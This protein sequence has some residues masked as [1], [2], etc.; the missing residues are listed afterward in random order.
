MVMDWLEEL[1]LS[2]SSLR[3]GVEQIRKALPWCVDHLIKKTM[4]SG[5][6]ANLAFCFRCLQISVL[7]SLSEPRNRVR[8]VS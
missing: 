1:Q 7:R 4:A 2:L 8:G 3:P 5:R 6:R